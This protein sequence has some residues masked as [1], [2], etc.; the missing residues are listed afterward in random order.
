MSKRALAEAAATGHSMN[1][2]KTEGNWEG[3]GG[4]FSIPRR[5]AAATCRKVAARLVDAKNAIDPRFKLRLELEAAHSTAV[6]AQAEAAAFSAK[7]EAAAWQRDGLAVGLYASR[8]ARRALQE[9][10]QKTDALHEDIVASLRTMVADE[11]VRSRM[12]RA[13]LAVAKEE[14]ATE[15]EAKVEVEEELERLQEMTK[16]VLVELARDADTRREKLRVLVKQLAGLQGKVRL[17][18]RACHSNKRVL[19][20]V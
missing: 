18:L 13:D 16:G 5:I 8:K 7:A 12:V 10:S 4:F 17:L 11:Q 6:K 15:K 1:K 19:N 14:L 9:E 20:Q 3:E 2:Y